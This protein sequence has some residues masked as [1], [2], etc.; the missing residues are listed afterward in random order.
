VTDLPYYLDPAPGT[1]VLPPRAAFDSDAPRLC[2]DGDWRFRW[3]PCIADAE[4]EPS[5]PDLDDQDWAELPVPAHWQ[6]HGYGNPAYTNVRYPFP[7]DPPYVPDANPTGDYR[8]GFDLP[9]DWPAGSTV[10]RFDGVDSCFRVWL[11]GVELGHATGSRLPTEFEVGELLLPTG[12]VLAVRVHQ[13]SAASYLE[14]QDMWWL[15]GIFRSVTLLARPAAGVPDFFV[16]A[17]Y[18]HATGAGTLRVEIDVPATFNIPELGLI[19]APVAETLTLSGIEP[20]SAEAPRLY[21]G[22]LVTAGERVPLR[23]GFRTVRFDEGVLTVNGR[24]VSLRGVNRHEWHPEHGRAVPAEAMRADLLLMKQHNINAVR[25]SHYPPHPDFLAL[26]DELGLWVIDECDLETHGFLF[27]EWRR[28]PADDPGWADALTD[29]MRRMVE[30]DKNHPSII[31]WSLGNECGVGANLAAMAGWVRERDPSRFVHYEG[32]RDSAHVDV[33]SRMYPTHAE[34]DE[35]G[36]RAEPETDDPAVD[37][38]RRGLPFLLCEYGHAMGAGPGGLSEYQELFERYPR[39]AG[40]F[41]W[42][43]IDHGVARLTEDHRPYFAYGGDF[44]EVVHDG[45]FVADGLLFPDRRPSPGLVEYKKVIEPVR[46]RPDPAAGTVEVTNAYD[47]LDTAHL[48][49][50][51]TVETESGVL[52]GGPLAVPVIAAGERA[53]VPLPE[54][55]AGLGETWLTVRATLAAEQAWAAAGHEI[56]WGQAR[57]SPAWP[58]RSAPLVEPVAEAGALLIGAGRFDGRTGR[59]VQLGA[60]PVEGPVVDLWRAPTDNDIAHAGESIET[61]W[62]ALGLGRRTHRVLEVRAEPE[63]LVV[64]T[65][66]GSA[67]LDLGFAADYHWSGD[68]ERLTLRLELAPLGDWNVPLPRIGLRWGLPAAIE[69]VRWFGGGPGEAYRDMRRAAR[70]GCHER[71]VDELQT[72]YVFPQENGNRVD[73]RWAELSTKDGYG[74]RIEGRPQFD[75]TARR[76]T[77]ED[78][79]A[80]RHPTD[81]RPRDRVFVHTDLAHHGLGSASCGPGVLPSHRLTLTEP[82]S[83]TVAVAPLVGEQG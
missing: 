64:R 19:D 39:I 6:L 15:S 73:V 17:D 52:G 63:E 59:L 5:A 3:S 82:V 50:D 49:F 8:R 42:E 34:V 23:I 69:R 83:F 65:R 79:D 26:C 40:G 21:H 38:H 7:V 43:W 70:V 62:R 16:H 20:W 30:R 74:V 24:P 35:I 36:R 37:A 75:L 9:A 10:L 72:P 12:N 27:V 48:A 25:T 80:A 4:P 22:E 66:V 78:L 14:D 54:L 58:A 55:P 11:N 33:Y 46:L 45:N 60:L 67:G 53:T 31:G 51:W 1:G 32:D 81:L 71:T 57:L 68:A 76:W 29:R 18:D 61:V 44:G 2:L 13:W 56:A 77:S 47:V 28:N 41:V